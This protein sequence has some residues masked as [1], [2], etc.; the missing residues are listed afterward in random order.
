MD[1]ER[2]KYNQKMVQ[3]FEVFSSFPG[4][5]H[6]TY[7][8]F[9]ECACLKQ[10]VGFD[11]MAGFFVNVGMMNKGEQESVVKE[12]IFGRN[13]TIGGASYSLRIGYDAKMNYIY[14]AC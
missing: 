5:Y 12:W 4:C 8:H 1:K 13:A 2:K 9:V 10:L 3:F 7:C 6:H 14:H 11:H